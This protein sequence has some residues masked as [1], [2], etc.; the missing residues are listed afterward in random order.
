MKRD[1]NL[2]GLSH[3]HHYALVLAR[4]IRLALEGDEGTTAVRAELA[5][6]YADWIQGHFD[7]EEELLLPALE[8]AGMQAIATRTRGEHTR[9]REL[10]GAIDGDDGVLGAFGEALS[11]HVRFEERELF[12]LCE[13]TLDPSVLAAV[14]ART[15]SAMSPTVP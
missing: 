6:H 1:P 2:V 14:A 10:H 13:R 3:H 5:E 4:H 7:V 9:L 12:P 15:K 11:E 8:A